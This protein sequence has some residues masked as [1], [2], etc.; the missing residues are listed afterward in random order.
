[1][2]SLVCFFFCVNKSLFPLPGDCLRFS[3]CGGSYVS[4]DYE[5]FL[6]DAR[7][8]CIEGESYL[9]PPPRGGLV[10]N[11][12]VYAPYVPSNQKHMQKDT[13][14]DNKPIIPGVSV[15]CELE[16]GVYA[17]KIKCSEHDDHPHFE[18]HGTSCGQPGCPRH[19]QQWAHRGADRVGCRLEG[20]YNIKRN[21]RYPP[22]H[23]VL[24]ISITDPLLEKLKK[25]KPKNQ[26][27]HLRKYFI[28]QAAA[29]GCTGGSLVIHTHRTNDLVPDSK[30][31]KKWDWV[32]S[33]GYF[34]KDFVKFS[35]HAH[36]NGYG[37][38]D[39]PQPGQFLY[40]NL[41][42]LNTRDDMEAAAFY[43]L[44]HAAIVP[45]ID[46]V[47]YFGNCGYRK[48]KLVARWRSPR[49]LLCQACGA[50]MIYED[51]G[52]VVTVRRTMGDYVVAPGPP[53]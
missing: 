25:M 14:Q 8:Y 44:S 41:G 26:L 10:A 28:Q 31:S 46:A 3:P 2:L 52:E 12:G 13:S 16:N 49:D 47:V 24:S 45:G 29:I 4:S 11:G 17:R 39:K 6:A 22:R 51:S 36:I 5:R 23:I 40:V 27:R 7:A 1:M 19:W 37:Y 50:V 20:F 32:R 43:Q 15:D 53:S 18:W 9:A 30:G 21:R 48:L 38:L 34:W 42:V 35:P 33:K